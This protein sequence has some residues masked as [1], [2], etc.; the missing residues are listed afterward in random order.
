MRL[1][2]GSDAGASGRLLRTLWQFEDAAAAIDETTRRVLW[3]TPN[4]WRYLCCR[5][6]DP[7]RGAYRVYPIEA[8]GPL[9]T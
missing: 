6:F 9:P 7:E 3:A 1:P 2:T 5:G 4:A 8:L